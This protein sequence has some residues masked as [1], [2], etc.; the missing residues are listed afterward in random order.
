MSEVYRLAELKDAEQLLDV[1]YRAYALIR[2]LGLHWPA[3]TAD[4]ALI[5]DNIAVNECYVLELDGVII[6]TITLSKEEEIKK[7]SPLPFIKWF[8]AHPDYSNKGY[9]GKLL[10]WVEEHVIL[11]QLGSPEVT[12]ATAQKHPWLVQMYERRGYERFLEL[13]PQNGDGMMYLLK[14]QLTDKPQ[15]IQRG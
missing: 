15:L 10:D 12:L 3:A 13:D 4:L 5:Q 2:E 7:L 1:T 11:G 6:A 9:G 14:K 8:A